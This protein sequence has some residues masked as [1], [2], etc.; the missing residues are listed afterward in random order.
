MEDRRNQLEGQI[1]VPDLMRSVLE[2]VSK[3]SQ[4]FDGVHVF[5]PHADV[6]DDGALRLIVL[7]PDQPY[8]KQDKAGA[9]EQVVQY[10]RNNG[11][12]PRYRSNRVLFIA[13]EQ[14]S[15]ERL[16]VAVR[17]TLAWESIVDD[18]D[19]RRLTVDRPQEDQ[20]KKELETARGALPRFARETFKWLL[21]PQMA[22]STERE[23]QVEV[24][25][26][27]AG[28]TG[29]AAD[30]DRVSDENE[31][32]ISKWAPIHLRTCLA[33]LY[34]K[35]EKP[36]VGAL[37]VWGDMEKYLYLPRLRNRAVFEKAVE[38]GLASADFFGAAYGERGGAYEGI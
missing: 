14:S 21:C 20:A 35:P 32:V 10:V 27:N 12:K 26:L 7:R 18:I 25:P 30:V 22:G 33:S 4:L 13:A 8:S 16:R 34:W 23:V 3:G 15:M 5:T 11:T 2:K 36:H 38:L 31:L 37:S 17:T 1:E 28:S 24:Y 29:F 19:G 9:F 6:P